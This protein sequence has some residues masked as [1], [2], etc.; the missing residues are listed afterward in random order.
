MS[1]TELSR[2]R[3]DS[4]IQLVLDF[5]YLNLLADKHPKARVDETGLP[6]CD[7]Q[8]GDDEG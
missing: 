5:D 8:A 2:L 1:P 3:R 4:A 6:L 7:Y